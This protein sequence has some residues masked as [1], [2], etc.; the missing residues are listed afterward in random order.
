MSSFSVVRLLQ[1]PLG[2]I[3][4]EG[5]RGDLV[6]VSDGTSTVYLMPWEFE[7]AD[8][9]DLRWLLARQ[10]GGLTRTPAPVPERRTRY[11]SAVR[12]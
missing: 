4:P 6:R 9:R 8:D 11:R 1:N 12:A 2:A 10:G 3:A 7:A 5:Q